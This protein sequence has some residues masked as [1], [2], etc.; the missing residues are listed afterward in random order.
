MNPTVP[1]PSQ[2]SAARVAGIAYLLTFA[3]VVSANFGIFTRLSVPGD[4]TATARNILAHEGL[5]RLYLA[6]NVVYIAGVAV[7]LTALYT[8]LGPVHRGL[9]LLAAISRLIFGLMWLLAT[10]IQYFVLRLLHGAPY[11]NVFATEQQ[12]ALA[13]LYLGGSFETYYVGLPFYALASTLCSYLWL[14]SGQIPRW[15]AASGVIASGWCVLT[16]VAFIAIPHFEKI[17]ND[18][19]F[20]SPMGLFELAVGGWLLFKGVRPKLERGGT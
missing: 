11:L 17:V 12:Q 2:R 7:L 1:D 13:K 5:F 10:V 19:L 16:A 6:C 9:A 15:L 4:A 14:K 8:L 20:D 3:V 18:W